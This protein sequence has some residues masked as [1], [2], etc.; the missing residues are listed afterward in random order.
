MTTTYEQQEIKKAVCGR[1]ER[2]PATDAEID[3]VRSIDPLAEMIESDEWLLYWD[4]GQGEC[5]T[6]RPWGL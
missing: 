4:D 5:S 6:Q 3:Y 1:T 2:R